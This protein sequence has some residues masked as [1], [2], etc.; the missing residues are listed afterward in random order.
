MEKRILGRTGWEV[1]VVG[2][3]GISLQYL[4]IEDAQAVL[5]EALARGINFFDTARSYTDSERKMS[6]LSRHGKKVIMATKTLARG[7]ADLR[8][9]LERSLSEL[10]RDRVDL[11]QLHNVSR[12]E[13]LE[14]ILSRRGALR[15]ARKAQEEGLVG[16]IGITSH[17]M[18]VALAALDTGEFSALQIPVNVVERHYLEGGL[19]ERCR[20][21]GV[22]LIAMKPLGGGPLLPAAYSLRF[23]LQAGTST[24]IPGMRSLREVRENAAVGDDPEPLRPEELEVLLERA[25]AVGGRFCRRCQYCLPCPEGIYI[26]QVFICVGTWRWRKEPQRAKELYRRTVPVPASFCRRCGECEERCPYGL[27]IM[28][29]LEEAS[30]LLE[31]G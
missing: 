2:F 10:D 3:G 6:C 14:K 19:V 15:G 1:S 24:V 26:P 31:E 8:E 22:G 16:E 9:D 28:D 18:E 12:V 5:E 7:E 30:R 11:Y 4:S 29:M 13:E 17:N 27:P 23:A 21:E 25:R 20:K